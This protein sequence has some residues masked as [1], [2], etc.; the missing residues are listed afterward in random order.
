M[1]TFVYIL[2]KFGANLVILTTCYMQ[3][4]SSTCLIELNLGNCQ[5][6]LMTFI[7]NV[8]TLK[9]LKARVKCIFRY[10]LPLN[11]W[12]KK[13]ERLYSAPRVLSQ[14]WAVLSHRLSYER[15]HVLSKLSLGF[16]FQI[17]FLA[18]VKLYFRI[19]KSIMLNVQLFN[20]TKV[21]K[22]H[23]NHW[24]VI[25]LS[26]IPFGRLKQH[27]TTTIAVQIINPTLDISKQTLYMWEH[28]TPM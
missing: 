27:T 1:T 26:S 9:K 22:K 24:I 14:K 20:I 18:K 25:N 12:K 2:P 19:N 5:H 6:Y 28:L 23:C 11:Q 8:I 15:A 10:K 3:L 13:S 7:I 21:P 17:S 16:K 4:K